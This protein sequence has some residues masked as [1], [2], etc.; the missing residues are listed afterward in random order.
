ML[1]RSLL[2]VLPA[3]LLSVVQVVGMSE[4]ARS[5]TSPRSPLAQN[6]PPLAPPPSQAKQIKIDQL[7]QQLRSNDSNV[8]LRATFALERISESAIPS[9]IPLLKDADRSVRW[10]AAEA[11]GSMGS[12]AK[13]EIPSLIP[14][15]KDENRDV[16]SV[17]AETLK[18]L[19]YQ[20]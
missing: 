3:V 16:R 14:L 1:T 10:A 11:L 15:L 9:L 19:G 18:K 8:R 20:P 6:T 4:V 12:S 7:I 17:A 13:A 5:Q 2:H